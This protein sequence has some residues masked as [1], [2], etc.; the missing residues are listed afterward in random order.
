VQVSKPDWLVWMVVFMGCLFVGID[1]GLAFG[2]GLSILVQL[3]HITFPALQVLG[4]ISSAAVHRSVL[5]THDV[6]IYSMYVINVSCWHHVTS[7]QLLLHI[8]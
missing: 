6:T 3:G 4:H 1:W 7:N 2:V 5:T 8:C